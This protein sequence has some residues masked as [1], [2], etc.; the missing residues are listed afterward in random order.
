M[1]NKKVFHWLRIDGIVLE[2]NHTENIQT[3][4]PPYCLK[5]HPFLLIF[6]C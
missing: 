1:R 4:R 5:L 2:S 6:F 3:G